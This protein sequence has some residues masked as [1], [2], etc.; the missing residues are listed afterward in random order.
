MRAVETKHTQEEKER[1]GRNYAQLL[2]KEKKKKN[3]YLSEARSSKAICRKKGFRAKKQIDSIGEKTP[4]LTQ[5]ARS[6]VGGGGTPCQ[7]QTPARKSKVVSLNKARENGKRRKAAL[8][9]HAWKRVTLHPQHPFEHPEGRSTK[10]W[11]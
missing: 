8:R 7:L 3:H 10:E 5:A 9:R 11:E 4:C 2:R 1:R 6:A